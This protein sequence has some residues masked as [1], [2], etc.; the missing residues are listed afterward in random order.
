MSTLLDIANRHIAEITAIRR[1]IHAHPELGFEETRT[2]ALVA[3]RLRGWGVDVTDG[4]A[5]TGVVG[6]IRGKRAGRGAIGLRA[7]MDALAMSETN[8][9]PHAST[10]PGRMHACGHDGHTAMLLGAAQALAEDPDFAGTVHLIFQPAEEARGGAEAMLAAGLFD[11]FPCDRIFGLHTYPAMPL[12]SFG[13]R[14]REMMAASGRFEVCFTGTGGH[15][16]EGPHRAADLS[17]VAAHF[18]LALQT[19]VARN[20]PPLEPAVVSVGHVAAGSSEALSVIPAE[21][22]IGGTMRA[23]SPEVQQ[24]L[25]TRI[26]ACAQAQ[27]AAEGAAAHV[28]CWWLSVPVVNDPGATATAVDAARAVVG[29][30]TV[31]DA[32]QPITAGEDFCYLARRRPGAFMLI[33]NGRH[34]GDGGANVHSPRYDFNDAALPLG[35]AYWL[36]VVNREL[37]GRIGTP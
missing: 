19:I 3:A 30:S 25:E 7:D 1:D 35:I 36:S 37:D 29:E 24:L 20:V 2:A 4:I 27:A 5:T 28:R 8:T 15:G 12:G 14:P 32:L 17:V 31:D 13:I 18:L 6:T 10:V 26:E 34:A 9:L 23:F 21:L 33:G 16:G 11:R 22:R